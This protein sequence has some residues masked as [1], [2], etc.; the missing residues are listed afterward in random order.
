MGFLHLTE[1]VFPKLFIVHSLRETHHSRS[2][3]NADNGKVLQE[4][5]DQ[6]TNTD[7]ERQVH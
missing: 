7:S 6:M 5:T 4:R 1:C 2:V 3:F